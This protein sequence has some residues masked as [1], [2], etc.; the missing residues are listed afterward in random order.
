MPIGSVLLQPNK[1]PAAP[2][3]PG[4]ALLEDA[5]TLLIR[6]AVDRANGGTVTDDIFGGFEASLQGILTDKKDGLEAARQHL[7]ALLTPVT[8]KVGSLGS[9]AMGDSTADEILAAGGLLI[10]MLAELAQNLTANEVHDR[11]DQLLTILT[12]DLGITNSALDDLIASLFDSMA[13]RVQQTPASA[14]AQTRDNR[15]QIATLL[16]RIQRNLPKAFLP[17]LNA[18]KLAG[19]LLDRMRRGS[20]DD[21]AKRA[22]VI[23]SAVNDGLTIGGTLLD[24]APFSFGFGDRGPGAASAGNDH[25]MNPLAWYASWLKGGEIHQGDDDANLDGIAFGPISADAMDAAAR[26]S[27]WVQYDL[28]LL[29]STIAYF[30]K[31]N[32]A[33]GTLQDIYTGLNG[34]LAAANVWDVPWYVNLMSS[35]TWVLLGSLEGRNPCGA[36]DGLLYPMRLMVKGLRRF[37]FGNASRMLRD[38]VLSVLTLINQRSTDASAPTGDQRLNRNEFI[39][40]SI[41]FTEL[42]NLIFAAVIPYTWYSTEFTASM[43]PGGALIGIWLACAFASMLLGLLFGFLAGWAISGTEGDFKPRADWAYFLA[44]LATFH[45]YWY[46][47]NEGDTSGGTVGYHYP[48]ATNSLSDAQKLTFPGYPDRDTSP[49]NLPFESGSSAECVQG[50]HGIF[51]HNVINGGGQVQNFAYDFSL[52]YSTPILCMRDG[53]IMGSANTFDSIPDGTKGASA[54]GANM[55]TVMHTTQDSTHDIDADGKVTITYALYLHGAQASV[56]S[57]LKDASGTVVA[58]TK[59][60]KGQVLMLVNS[61]GVSSFNHVHVDVRP[62]DGTAV[63]AKDGKPPV[64][65]TPKNYTIPFVFKEVSGNGVPTS[66]HYYDSANT[67]SG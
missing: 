43:H 4:S 48:G 67:R 20:Y 61:T 1:V 32:Y 53:V 23:G 41:L 58:G 52:P 24:V 35:T 13:G 66:N 39:G 40:L 56:S 26:H 10:G 37:W 47:L 59:V 38:S 25:Y 65:G 3:N 45:A 54:S 46:F 8:S 49:Y 19:P 44:A 55:V 18:D 21:F 34:I 15:T 36:H 22:G 64:I 29:I 16:R 42:W 6:V 2:P 33:N 28:E 14:D 57:A 60:T 12:T 27:R 11:I 17:A 31:G 9:A 63:L 62:D 5:I 30:R 51:S 7:E 50:N